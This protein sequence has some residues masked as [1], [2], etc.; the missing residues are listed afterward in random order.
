MKLSTRGLYALRVL[1]QL[2]MHYG[3]A[4]LSVAEL[5]RREGIST[6]YLEQI[7]ATLKKQGLLISTRGKQGGYALRK[8]PEQITLGDIIR[9][10]DGPLAPIACASR[11]APFVCSDGPY[12]Y[13]T[14]WIR[15][16][17]LRVRDN[18]SAILDQETL[19]DMVREA[20][21]SKRV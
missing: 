9:S 20:A 13:E 10:V 5:A 18:I 14:C 8:P 1:S 4:P 16:L 15:H 2:A 21:K 12:E 17:M 7:I 11:T 6:K 3:E 19:A